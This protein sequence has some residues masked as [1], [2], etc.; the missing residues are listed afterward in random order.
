LRRH[1]PRI[2]RKISALLAAATIKDL[3]CRVINI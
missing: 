2:L 1:T 3:P